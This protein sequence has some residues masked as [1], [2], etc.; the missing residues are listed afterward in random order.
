MSQRAHVHIIATGIR[1]ASLTHSSGP[2]P[3]LLA[4]RRARAG[5]RFRPEGA[6]V[7]NR[8]VDRRE[9]ADRETRDFRPA[10]VACVFLSVVAAE[11]TLERFL[12]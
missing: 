3:S 6:V 8:F 11:S 4:S 1:S 2:S 7:F 5:L 12:F 9:S 10:H